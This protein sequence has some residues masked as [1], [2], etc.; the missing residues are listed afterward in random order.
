MRLNFLR[1]LVQEKIDIYWEILTP[2]EW[3]ITPLQVHEFLFALNIAKYQTEIF[4][5]RIL[6]LNV[7][8]FLY[9][10]Y[11][12]DSPSISS[13]K[14]FIILHVLWKKVFIAEKS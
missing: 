14:V 1:Y 8:Y 7:E 12:K 5:G 10:M 4:S 13:L 11:F 3:T 9:F 2:F 6:A